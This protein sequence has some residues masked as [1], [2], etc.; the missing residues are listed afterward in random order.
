M[1]P[2]IKLQA[3]HQCLLHQG[4]AWTALWHTTWQQGRHVS[5]D[6][7]REDA[8]LPQC[9]D[10]RESPVVHHAGPYMQPSPHNRS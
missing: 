2:I 10:S 3:L 1:W 8:A 6:R 5:A 4:A 9:S 7:C